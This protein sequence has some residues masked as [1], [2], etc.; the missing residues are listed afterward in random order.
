MERS[1]RTTVSNAR[2]L[3]GQCRKPAGWVG[4][5]FLWSMNRRHSKST[6]WGLRQITI[7]KRD[8]ILDVGCGG[9][10]TLQKLSALTD[11]RV[12]GVDHSEESVA[13]ARRTN[14]RAVAAGRVDIRLGDVADLPF[15]DAA[16]DV[17]TAVETHFFWPDLPHDV[18]EV[19][20]VLK[21]GGTLLLVAEI[22][23]GGKF[24]RRAQLLEDHADATRM[25]LLT[26][27]EHRQLLLDAGFSDVRVLDDYDKGWIC[28]VG[29]N[30]S[31]P[32]SSSS[33]TAGL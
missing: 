20:R 9:G 25:T 21:P 18:A 31:S 15:A 24:A 26:V 2:A 4:R 8:T 10:R 7:G 6:D 14:R 23:K 29:V 30:H 22:Y 13:A 27:D 33:G 3:L 19:R 28:A 17:V 32:N 5:F 11:A 12:Y 16:F 1:S